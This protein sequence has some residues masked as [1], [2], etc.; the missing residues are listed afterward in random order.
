MRTSS[1][2]DLELDRLGPFRHAP[3]LVDRSISGLFA[4]GQVWCLEWPGLGICIG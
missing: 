3:N 4:S 2:T 1:V